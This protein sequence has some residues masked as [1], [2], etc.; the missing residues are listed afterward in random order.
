MH[1]NPSFVSAPATLMKTSCPPMVSG[2]AVR[3]SRG[4]TTRGPEAGW[5]LVVDIGNSFQPM[6][7]VQSG[8]FC[9]PRELARLRRPASLLFSRLFHTDRY[10]R[11]GRQ[12]VCCRPH[13][14]HSPSIP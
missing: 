11:W 9:P 7:E 14:E 13:A 5:E 8:H 1:A 6:P 2:F 4:P 10:P 3:P 12:L